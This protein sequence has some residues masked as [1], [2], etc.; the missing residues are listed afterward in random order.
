MC[1]IRR[2]WRV[3]NAFSDLK[4]VWHIQRIQQLRD[5]QD[6]VPTHLQLIISDLCNQDCHFCAYRMDGGF[7]TE[8]FADEE[9]NKNPKR[10]MPK[11]KVK[12]ILLD[13]SMLG[14]GAVQFTGGGEPTVHPNWEELLDYAQCLGM[15]TGLVTNGIKLKPSPVLNRLTWLR[16]SLDAGSRITYETVRRH[17][18]WDKAMAALEL[19]G[20]LK[21]PLVGV[22]FVITA[23]NWSEIADA[24]HLVKAARIPYIRLSAMFSH[25]GADYYKGLEGFIENERLRAKSLEDSKFQV[26]DF[27]DNRVKDLEM[28]TP[29]YNFCGFQQFV[30]YIGADQKVYTCC[31]NAYTTHGEIG[32]LREQRFAAWMR[33]HRRYDFDARS[34]HH[35]QF[36]D[37]NKIINYMLSEPAHVEFV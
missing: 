19:A 9:G 4:A 24:A 1:S 21:G 30:L 14:V 10:W 36:N 37:K 35:C 15:K 31:T 28:A 34:C 3:F 6:I 20:S 17:R 16:I 2:R 7:S 11:E 25:K 27:F 5:K 23:E 32:D 8:N 13:A 29:D 26:V 12:E 33:S 18:G 22:G